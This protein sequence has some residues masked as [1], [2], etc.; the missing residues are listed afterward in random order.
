[1]HNRYLYLT[2]IQASKQ[3]VQSL[4]RR[5]VFAGNQASGALPLSKMRSSDQRIHVPLPIPARLGRVCNRGLI[6]MRSPRPPISINKF[7]QPLTLSPSLF[8]PAL[9]ATLSNATCLRG[10]A[11]R[12]SHG[13]IVGRLFAR[14]KQPATI[15]WPMK[16]I[17]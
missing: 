13:V 3:S 6:K 11:L 12:R 10:S 4:W 14:E 8:F 7:F 5:C 15:S 9:V 2:V 1:M 16:L 17:Y